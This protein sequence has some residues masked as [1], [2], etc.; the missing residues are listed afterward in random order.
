MYIRG[1][2][3]RW[4]LLGGQVHNL[5]SMGPTLGSLPLAAALDA[6]DRLLDELVA[7]E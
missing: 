1:T 4:G 5:E 6:I 7:V 3:E 2:T